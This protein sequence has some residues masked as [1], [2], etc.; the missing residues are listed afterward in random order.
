[1]PPFN[2]G[3]TLTALAELAISEWSNLFEDSKKTNS[4]SGLAVSH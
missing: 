4:S 2:I 3:E 1:M